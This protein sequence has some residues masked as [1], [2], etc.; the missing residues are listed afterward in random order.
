MFQLTFLL[1]NSEK[2]QECLF[3]GLKINSFW[4]VTYISF[5]LFKMNFSLNHTS[6]TMFKFTS[7]FR[8]SSYSLSV[9]FYDMTKMKQ[10]QNIS[11]YKFII[12][13]VWN[14]NSCKIGFFWLF[15]SLSLRDLYIINMV[16]SYSNFYHLGKTGATFLSFLLFVFATLYPMI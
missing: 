16:N 9:V 3:Y 1:L 14:R 12:S 8:V 5:F 6:P 15:L 11:C 10:N 7:V 2:E 4:F 13:L